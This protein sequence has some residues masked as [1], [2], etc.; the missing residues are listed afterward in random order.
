M[1][2]GSKRER[3]QTLFLLYLKGLLIIQLY[4]GYCTE[5]ARNEYKYPTIL[6]SWLLYKTVRALILKVKLDNKSLTRCFG[7]KYRRIFLLVFCT[8]DTVDTRWYSLFVQLSP[9]GSSKYSTTRKSIRRY[10][11]PKHLTRE[12]VRRRWSLKREESTCCP[13]WETVDRLLNT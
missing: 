12:K 3:P 1:R 4:S 8:V 5:S 10:F 9:A 11:T 6:Y 2:Q 13:I 7:V